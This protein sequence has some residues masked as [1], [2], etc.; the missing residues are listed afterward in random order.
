MTEP[1]QITQSDVDAM[2]QWWNSL[3]FPLPNLSD[4]QQPGTYWVSYSRVTFQDFYWHR[5]NRIEVSKVTKLKVGDEYRKV[6]RSLM[7]IPAAEV[8]RWQHYQQIGKA[9]SDLR[10]E[11]ID[12][13][14]KA[15]MLGWQKLSLMTP[16][17]LRTILEILKKY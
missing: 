1:T 6:M 14:Q 4:V 2:R 8:E 7:I 17:D 16:E 3:R 11:V 12:Q 10:R 9:Y 15:P 13:M 5:L